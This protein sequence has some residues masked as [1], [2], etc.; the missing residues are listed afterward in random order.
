VRRGGGLTN[1]NE[2]NLKIAIAAKLMHPRIQVI[3]RADSHDV[4]ANMASF[5]TDHI[6]D[7]FDI[8]ALH[9]AIAIEAPCL[10]LMEDWLTGLSGEPSRSPSIPP[11]RGCGSSAATG[12]SA[13]PCTAPQGAGAARS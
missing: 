6:Y 3:C 5:G 11:P 12:A 13:R 8:F 2:V 10:V 9:L 4:E 1:V 7:P